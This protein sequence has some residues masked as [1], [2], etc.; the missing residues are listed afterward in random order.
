[1]G[2]GPPFPHNHF[3]SLY[4]SLYYK[5]CEYSHHSVCVLGKIEVIFLQ[6]TGII[7]GERS[8]ESTLKQ[9]CLKLV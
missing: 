4:Y 8:D 3:K 6:K 5:K 1:M 7:L 9:C 2:D